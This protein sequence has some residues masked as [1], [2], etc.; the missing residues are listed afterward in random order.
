MR[1]TAVWRL[2]QSTQQ[3]RTSQGSIEKVSINKQTSFVLGPEVCLVI[4]CFLSRHKALGFG[5][6]HQGKRNN[7]D[8]I[9]CIPATSRKEVF[10]FL[11]FENLTEYKY[12]QLSLD[13][14]GCPQ[15]SWYWNYRQTDIFFS[16]LKFLFHIMSVLHT[17]CSWRSEN[18]IRSPEIG[19]HG[20]L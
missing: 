18:S 16:D 2:L 20:Q 7:P 19:V 4:E 17:W 6:Q 11:S 3:F 14:P 15:H 12:P 8:F 13:S 1:I 5:L 9:Y 10:R